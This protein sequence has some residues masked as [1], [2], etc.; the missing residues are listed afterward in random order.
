MEVSNVIAEN[1]LLDWKKKD[2]SPEDK[3]KFIFAYLKEEKISMRELGRRLG[4][5]HSTLQDWISMRQINIEKK[6]QRK[7]NN[8]VQLINKLLILIKN[9]KDIDDKT[10]KKIRELK[11]ELEKFDV[12]ELE[13]K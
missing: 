3:S 4:I 2:I 1:I 6:N 8:I 13:E 12:I 5:S 11:S 10:R 9:N 7:E